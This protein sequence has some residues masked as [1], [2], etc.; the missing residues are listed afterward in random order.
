M[1]EAFNRFPSSGKIIGFL[2]VLSAL[3]VSVIG[4]GIMFKALA[5]IG[6]V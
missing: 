4:M 2:P 5:E 3:F 6:I 1:Q